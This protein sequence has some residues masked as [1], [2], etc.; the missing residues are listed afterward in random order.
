MSIRI[1]ESELILT[2]QGRVYH[3]NLSPEM[4]ADTIIVVG[5]PERVPKVSCYFDKVEHQVNSRELVTHT[6]TLGGKRLSV[7]SS[8][9]GT[10]NVELLMT[11][12]DALVNVNLETREIKE[13]LKSLQIIRIGTSGCL[14][15]EIPIDA[16]LVSTA[17]LGLD[18][19]MNFYNW[20]SDK[21]TEDFTRKIQNELSLSFQPYFAKASEKLLSLFS[22]NYY[23]GVTIT[24]PGFYAPQGR[25]VRL[26]PRVDGLVDRLAAM[27]TPFGQFT[28]LEMET[29]GYYAMAQLLGHE[30]ISLNALIANRARQEFSKNHESAVDDLIKRVLATLSA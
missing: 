25:Q 29:A 28:N 1:P 5:D 14:Q 2:P 22:D 23:Q 17:A 19:L 9:M 4:V 7:I 24:A 20:T 26:K 18:T 3:L 27:N 21:V 16:F 30:M 15:P 8:G 10:D 6:G 13:D 12:L 11:E